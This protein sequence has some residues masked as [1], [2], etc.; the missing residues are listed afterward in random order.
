MERRN[1]GV[2][3]GRERTL[4]LV[5]HCATKISIFLDIDSK[6]SKKTHQHREDE[7]EKKHEGI[8]HKTKRKKR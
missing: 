6:P 8:Q 2:G 3:K 4:I 5:I 7:F 1:D